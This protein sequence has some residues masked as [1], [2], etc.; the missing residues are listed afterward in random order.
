MQ[1]S[2]RSLMALAGAV[3]LV[4]GTAYAQTAAPAAPAAAKPKLVAP[5]RGE[6]EIQYLLP[7]TKREG[8]MIVT[9]IKIKNVAPIANLKK[10][11]S[12]YLGGNQVTDIKP[13]AGLKDLDTINLSGNGLSDI[14]ALA[15]LQ[16]S[17][18]LFLQGNQ[19]ADLGVLV[20]M[21]K[22]DAEGEKAEKRFALYWY[23]D[24]SGNPL[25][26]GAKTAQLAELRKL[27]NPDRI[28]FK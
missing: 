18:F 3:L 23:I 9:T 17:K 21:A 25:N 22:K 13:L 14:S 5:V 12:L 7:V 15:G 8:K 6:A 19:I 26:D 4:A 2:I 11:W 1:G 27:G 24:V 28:I 16:P 10:M 20:G